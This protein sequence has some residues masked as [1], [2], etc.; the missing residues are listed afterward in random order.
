[1]ET[2]IRRYWHT[3]SD[4]MYEMSLEPIAMAADWLFECYQRSG[5]VFILGNGG[6][7][8]TASHLACDLGK[9]TRIDG[10]PTFR[11]ACLTDNIPLLTAW[12]N[13]SDYGDALAEQLAAFV[14]KDDV[15]VAISVSGNS[16]N[17]LNAVNRARQAGAAVIGL[18]G[19][20]GGR[21]VESVNLPIRVPSDSAEEVED[22]HLIAAHSIC[23]ALRNRFQ[24]Q[25][26]A[27]DAVLKSMVPSESLLARE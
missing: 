14:T 5:T 2:D 21:L 1:M 20:S 23:T 3:V 16:V 18:T 17:V 6:S 19:Q 25:R 27:S 11:T 22:V 9:G 12:S 26:A 24:E 15:V 13:D 7:A 4:L 8:A 10:R